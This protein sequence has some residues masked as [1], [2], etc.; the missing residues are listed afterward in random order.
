MDSDG[1]SEGDVRYMIDVLMMNDATTISVM[2][3]LIE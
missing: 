1:W 2:D 3:R